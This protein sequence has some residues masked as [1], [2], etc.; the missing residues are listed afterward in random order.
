MRLTRNSFQW[1][2]QKW[3]SDK[4][5]TFEKRA[6]LILKEFDRILKK[7]SVAMRPMVNF[8]GNSVPWLSKL[9][10]KIIEKQG[11]KLDLQLLDVKNK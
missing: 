5:M 9:A 11:G 6:T 3:Y 7:E 4:N 8:S 10:L 2:K 1:Q